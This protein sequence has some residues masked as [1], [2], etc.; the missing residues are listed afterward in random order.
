MTTKASSLQ[1]W[2]TH[3]DP[4]DRTT[5]WSGTAF[6]LCRAFAEQGV[7]GGAVA[8]GLQQRRV[9]R[10]LQAL[11][12]RWA[13]ERRRVTTSLHWNRWYLRYRATRLKKVEGP[14]RFI[15]QLSDGLGMPDCPY[16][17]YLDMSLA[18]LVPLKSSKQ[19]TYMFDQ[20]SIREVQARLEWERRVMEK[21]AAIFVMSDWVKDSLVLGGV[22]APEKVHVVGVG[23]NGF[24]RPDSNWYLQNG[25]ERNATILFVGRDFVR[26]GG[27]LLVEA[28]QK[29]RQR[30]SYARLVIVGPEHRGP[31]RDGIQY[32]GRVDKATLRSLYQQATV[33]CLPSWF[34]A[35]GISFIEALYFGVPIVGLNRFS[36]PDIVARTQGGEGLDD[37]PLPDRLADVLTRLL[38]SPRQL[39]R[40]SAMGYAGSEWYTWPNTVKRI[41]DVAEQA[42]HSCVGESF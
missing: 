17:L 14:G 16:G 42:A 13:P 38:E 15:L 1:Y 21:A 31:D 29:V 25:S 40:L 8:L 28:F 2:L 30:V 36:F 24:Q 18:I 10:G 27:P 6:S 3:S 7:F 32:M 41:R 5:T 4:P 34:D 22:A 26:K 11:T 33:F 12:A 39:R 9:L 37:P 19:T 23:A 20:Y 35:F